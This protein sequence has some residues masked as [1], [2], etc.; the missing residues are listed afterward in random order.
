[1]PDL[2]FSCRPV[3]WR[4]LLGGGGAAL[5]LWLL[6]GLGGVTTRPAVAQAAFACVNVT[7]I[8]Q[9]ECHALVTLYNSTNGPAWVVKSGWLATNTPCTWVGVTCTGNHVTMLLLPDNGLNG[10]LPPELG[11]LIY[12]RVLDLA[13]NPPMTA[14]LQSDAPTLPADLQ[15]A[16]ATADRLNTVALTGAMHHLEQQ[17]QARAILSNTRRAPDNNPITAA[18]SLLPVDLTYRRTLTESSTYLRNQMI[19]DFGF[20]ILDSVAARAE[21]QNP[22]SKIQNPRASRLTILTPSTLT[23]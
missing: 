1:M 11:A 17:V 7:E 5:L 22:K 8:P 2:L 6:F 14:A 18:A 4:R 16:L 19:L 10:S 13:E 12:L 3:L 23:T 21:I 20:S 15:P 9:P